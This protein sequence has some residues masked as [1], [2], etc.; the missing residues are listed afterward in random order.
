MMMKFII[1]RE[2]LLKPLQHITAPLSSRPI[3]PIL[4]NVLLHVTDENTLYLTGTD[5]EI[6]MVAV[7]PL[8]QPCV[9]GAITIPGKKFFDI[10]RSLP[11]NAEV[12]VT[13]EE[14]KREP[15]ESLSPAA[16]KSRIV[17]SSQRSR[18]SLATLPAADYPNLTE[19]KS[20]VEFHVPQS[21]LKRLL[22]STQFAMA[23]Q[24]VRYYLNG[25]L[26]ETEGNLLR[27]VATDGHR[28][29]V[30]ALPVGQ[31]LPSHSVIVPRKGIIEL[32]RLLNSVDDPVLLQFGSNNLRI[33]INELIFTC[34][35]VDGLFPDY[36]R[37]LPQNPDKQI[38]APC[39]SLKHA[40]S[41]AAILSNEKFRGVRLNLNNNQLKITANN[42]EQEEA[43]EIV[44]I[45]YSGDALE[46]GFNVTYILDVL[47]TLRCDNI[48]LLLSNPTSSALIENADDDSASYVIMPMRL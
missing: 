23:H 2:Q 16:E 9:S 22:E 43:E 47:G 30:C 45:H 44:D 28:L 32:N 33:Q 27:A 1:N 14:S 15:T 6:E 18:F 7:I 11:D 25:L 34:K 12:T 13:L 3:L 24:D 36:R 39:E 31:E 4:G 21:T 20:D 35:L 8:E 19:W 17:I 46:I 29:A 38:E 41:R 10:C 5:L 48:R 37:V 40:F 26:F 42:P